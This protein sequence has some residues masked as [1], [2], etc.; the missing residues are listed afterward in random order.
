M[1]HLRLDCIRIRDAGQQSAAG[2]GSPGNRVGTP[3]VLGMTLGDTDWF[4]EMR[5]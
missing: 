4:K 2:R 5:S 3:Y 1:E